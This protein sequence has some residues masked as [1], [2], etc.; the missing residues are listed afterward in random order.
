MTNIMQATAQP[1]LAPQTRQLE[2]TWR[3]WTRS[4]ISAA[5]KRQAARGQGQRR[6]CAC[7]AEQR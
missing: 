2:Q 5:K 4:A 1:L 3:S 6:D 7:R